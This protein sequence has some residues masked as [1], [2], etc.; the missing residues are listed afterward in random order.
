MYFV[1]Q[2]AANELPL[3]ETIS[4]SLNNF[5]RLRDNGSAE[6]PFTLRFASG[7]Q[8][9]NFI[10]F[11]HVHAPVIWDPEHESDKLFISVNESQY[12]PINI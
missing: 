4:N 1:S 12:F 11:L 8:I 6:N 9:E 7:L 10:K 2:P 3:Y 5:Y